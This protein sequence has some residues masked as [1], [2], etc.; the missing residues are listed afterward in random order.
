ME[1]GEHIFGSYFVPPV[2]VIAFIALISAI[3]YSVKKILLR[4]YLS[5]LH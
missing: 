4:V 1:C 5:Y 3:T 2:L